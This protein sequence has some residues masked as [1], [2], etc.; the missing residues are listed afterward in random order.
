MCK[1]TIKGYKYKEAGIN[2]NHLATRSQP[3]FQ[4]AFLKIEIDK[5]NLKFIWK[6]KGTRLANVGGFTLFDSKTSGNRDNMILA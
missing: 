2:G 4:K 5:L 1:V 3:K 6:H